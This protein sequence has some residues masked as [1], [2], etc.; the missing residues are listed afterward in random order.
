MKQKN[1]AL[2]LLSD[3]NVQGVIQV[4]K[5]ALEKNP[6]LLEQLQRDANELYSQRLILEQDLEELDVKQISKWLKDMNPQDN[7]D[8]TWEEAALWAISDALDSLE[9]RAASNSVCVPKVHVSPMGPTH[10]ECTSLEKLIEE[11]DTIGQLS[12]D[13]LVPMDGGGR[14]FEMEDTIDVREM[15]FDRCEEKLKEMGWA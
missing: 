1:S 8:E 10:V 2:V 11:L 15:L 7:E 5:S 12:W 14:V 4:R 9:F 3:G 6:E 13:G